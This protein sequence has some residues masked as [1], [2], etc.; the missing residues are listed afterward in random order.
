MSVYISTSVHIAILLL[1]LHVVV[2]LPELIFQLC[3][4][5]CFSLALL[6]T[7]SNIKEK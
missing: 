5:D 6:I 2:F 3:C 4:Y 1:S 7:G